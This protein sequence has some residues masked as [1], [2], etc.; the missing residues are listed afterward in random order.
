MKN[1]CIYKQVEKNIN[2]LV[3]EN[4]NWSIP[5]T[6]EAIEA[7]K[8]GE[9]NVSK[10]INKKMPDEWF[11]K[12]LKGVKILCLAGAGGQ[13]APLLAA[14]GAEVTVL[15]LSENMLKRDEMV[16]ARDALFI[17]TEHGNMCDLSRFSD[18]SFDM[19]L[20]PPSLFYVPDVLP[21]FQ[22]CYRVLK[23]GGTFSM[24]AP[25][26]SNYLVE[27]DKDS[28]KYIACNKLP[29][30]SAEH[31]DQG[32]WIEYGHTLES[33]IGG[34]IKCGFSIIGFYEDD[35]DEQNDVNSFCETSFVTR[36]IK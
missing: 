11:P 2:N 24:F 23:K 22:E 32:D 30:I 31:A 1:A 16:A 6:H 27:Y 20:N 26:P 5:V 36:A 21:V 28:G 18:E 9:L 13:Q 19:I 8:N 17:R 29:Y 15:D 3:D 7:I 33:Y 14:A 10:A 35:F 25:N 34:Q 4:V 12:S